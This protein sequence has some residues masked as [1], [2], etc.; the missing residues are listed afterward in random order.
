MKAVI[1]YTDYAD[2]EHRIRTKEFNLDTIDDLKLSD[3]LL[4]DGFMM[5]SNKD[6]SYALV[7][8]KT[9]LIDIEIL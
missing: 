1:R 6:S 9:S 4:K 3:K 5:V 7:I 2:D 8:Q